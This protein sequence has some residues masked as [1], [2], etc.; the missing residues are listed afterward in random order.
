[1]ISVVISPRRKCQITKAMAEREW[2]SITAVTCKSL[3]HLQFGDNTL[4]L[5]R[6]KRIRSQ[7]GV[8]TVS[9]I[10]YDSHENGI[11]GISARHRD[12]PQGAGGAPS[13]PKAHRATDLWVMRENSFSKPCQASRQPT[14]AAAVEAAAITTLAMLSASCFRPSRPPST[15]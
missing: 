9:L 3:S 7:A 15:P 5:C 11:S 10:G 6:Y 14:A 12:L 2:D 13:G 1:L 8:S 4:C